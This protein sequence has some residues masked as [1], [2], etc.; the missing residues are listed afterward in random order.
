MAKREIKNLELK[1]K[2][3]NEYLRTGGVEK[4]FDPGLLEDLTKVKS[5]PDGKPDPDTVS[6]RV[7][8]FMMALLSSHLSPPVFNPEYISEYQSLLQKGLSFEQENVDTKEQFDT[9]FADYKDEPDILFRGQAEAKWRLYSKAQ[10]LWIMDK[11]HQAGIP[12]QA[13]LEMLV[14]L[15]RDTYLKQIQETLQQFHIDTANDIAV[16]GFL[17]HHGCPTPLMDWTF[18]FKTG[19]FFATDGAAFTENKYEIDQ[20]FSLYHL[21]KKYFKEGSMRE[22]MGAS[23]DTVGKEWVDKMIVVIAG[24]DPEKL[25]EMQEKFADRSFFVRAKI[26]GAGLVEHMT[27]MSRMVNMPMIYFSDDDAESGI[28]FSLK[29]SKN[30]IKQQ[31]VFI[32]TSSPDRPFEMVGAEQYAKGKETDEPEEFRFCKC[33]N[34]HKS[35][36]PYIREKLKVEGISAE[37]IYPT[38]S[39]EVDTWPLYEQAK[40]TFFK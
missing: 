40:T 8:A 4:I 17:Q 12:Y 20:Y 23:L 25:K 21:E 37:T 3:T 26:P 16:L 19:L 9:L 31:G 18:D 10:R 30:I 27:E 36:L 39:D 7:N 14:N 5:G 28:V 15:G 33:F 32:W 24:D 35:L 1:I 34:I 2:L 29:N 13:L 11:W 22:I 6:T 38:K